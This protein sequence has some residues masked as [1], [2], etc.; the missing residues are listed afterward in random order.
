M[1]YIAFIIV[2]LAIPAFVTWIKSNSPQAKWA[3]FGLGLLP[4]T[5]NSWNLDG[6]LIN[7]AAWPGYVKGI[8]LTMMDA[9]ALAVIMTHRSPRGLPPLSGYLIAYILAAFLSVAMADVPMGSLFYPFQLLRVLIVMVAVAKIVHDERAFTW[10]AMG[11]AAGISYQA[12]FCIWQRVNGAFQTSGTMGHQNLL[13]LMAQFVLIL[14][15]ALLAQG[16]RN[17]L[18]MLGV[19]SSLTVIGL[20][21]SRG[22]VGFSLLGVSL[23]MVLSILRQPTRRKWQVGGFAALALVLT[24]PLIVQGMNNRFEQLARN[25]QSEGLDLERQAFERAAKAMLADHPFGVGANQYVVVANAQGYSAR[26]GVIWNWTSRAANVHNTYLLVA[27]ET[28]WLGLLTFIVM[29]AAIG[30]AGWRFAFQDRRDP[31]GEVVLGCAVTITVMAVH[32]QYEWIWVLYQAQ[33]AFAIMIGII[34]GMMRARA[35]ERRELRRR[36]A[37]EM[38]ES[39]I[40]S[41]PCPVA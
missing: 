13:G 9:L 24:S 7:W 28:G 39:N 16:S 40:A 14:L 17:R 37:A 21:A 12:G 35:I 27:A 36:R 20:G 31:R 26:A 38:L 15:L 4:F 33:Y 30:L 10:L 18:V 1:H 8:V 25:G 23:F 22:A 32:I 41:V 34:A 6:S 19:V 2:L 5:L 11:L 29:F 3:Y